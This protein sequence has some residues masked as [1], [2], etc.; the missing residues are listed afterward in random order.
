VAPLAPLH[1]EERNG[2]SAPSNS[3]GSSSSPTKSDGV[4]HPGFK[5]DANTTF[6]T[7]PVEDAPRYAEDHIKRWRAKAEALLLQSE[8]VATESQIF[9]ERQDLVN[10]QNEADDDIEKLKDELK[11]LRCSGGA[12]K[13][14]LSRIMNALN[15]AFKNALTTAYT[16]FIL[17]KE[18]AKQN[19][20]KGRQGPDSSVNSPVGREKDLANR[21]LP[22]DSE[23]PVTVIYG[24]KGPTSEISPAPPP[25]AARHQARKDSERKL[26]VFNRSLTYRIC[27]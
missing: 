23:E 15:T 7:T 4:S 19:S 26:N 8:A 13:V 27:R 1:V 11:G 21:G 25:A 17:N 24:G 6:G 10:W 20:R 5:T 16:R 22:A 12:E 18:D 3:N 9:Q 14:E 2:K